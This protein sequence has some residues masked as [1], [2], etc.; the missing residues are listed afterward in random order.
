MCERTARRGN[1]WKMTDTH[2]LKYDRSPVYPFISL[3]KAEERAKAFWLKHR[4]ESARLT[5]VA[6]TWGYGQKS[7][8][9]QQTVGALKQYGLIEDSGTGDERKIQL[10]E[11]GMR[12]VADNREGAREAALKEAAL[13]PRLFQEYRRWFVDTPSTQHCLSELELDRGFNPLAARTF[14]KSLLDT[15]KIAGLLGDD[16]FDSPNDLE[17]EEEARN[18]DEEQSHDDISPPENLEALTEKQ[19][20]WLMNAAALQR[21]AE[22]VADATSLKVEIGNDRIVVA[23]SL[24]SV[25]DVTKLIRI[26][27]ANKILLEG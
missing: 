19:N 3:R 8:G 16:A 24:R 14:L 13:R 23:A 12:L 7:S 18:P 9:L 10:T 22:A 6:T 25:E 11:L 2:K 20:S 17:E 1:R 21:A 4:R 15:G 26:L 27:E 5:S